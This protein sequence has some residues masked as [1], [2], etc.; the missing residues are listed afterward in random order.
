MK[1]Y[2]NGK[3]EDVNCP[4]AEEFRDYSHKGKK[5]MA[6]IDLM[7][8]HLDEI[9]INTRS[10]NQ[11]KVIAEEIKNMRNDLV[12]PATSKNQM[13][14]GAYFITITVFGAIIFSLMAGAYDQKIKLSPGNISVERN[15]NK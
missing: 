13:S 4:I 10:L 3:T 8:T 11:L 5:A 1:D 6:Q 2:E 12:G 7:R 14:I 15:S 9:V